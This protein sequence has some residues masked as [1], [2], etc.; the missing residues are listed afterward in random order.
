MGVGRCGPDRYFFLNLFS[1]FFVIAGIWRIRCRPHGLF[2]FCCLAST[3]TSP[4]YYYSS[5]PATGNRTQV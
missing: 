4:I 5:H 1:C 3:P 2:D